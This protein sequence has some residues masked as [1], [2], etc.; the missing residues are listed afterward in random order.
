MRVARSSDAYDVVRLWELARARS[1]T[2]DDVET[3]RALVAH[4]PDA[5][6]VTEAG[7]EL[8]GT[9]V[10]GYDGWRA[11]L[12]RLVVH[13]DWR[14]Q[15]VGLA[16]VAEAERRLGA[17]GAKRVSA[18]VGADDHAAAFWVAAGYDP[19]PENTRYVKTIK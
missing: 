18:I 6:L 17:R 16:L 14:R 1:T 2:T 10:G 15:G 9:L 4:D 19:Q 12:Y 3:V 8:I 5:L 11:T 7:G 13:P